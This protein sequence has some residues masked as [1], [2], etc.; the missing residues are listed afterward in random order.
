M[1]WLKEKGLKN[2]SKNLK[3]YDKILSREYDSLSSKRLGKILKEL[4]LIIKSKIIDIDGS[5]QKNT[6][7][8]LCAG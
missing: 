3:W 2:R 7:L 1:L 4:M 8:E 5:Y 6:V